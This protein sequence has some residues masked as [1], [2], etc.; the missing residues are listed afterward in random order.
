MRLASVPFDFSL[1]LSI[2]E[3]AKSDLSKQLTE[4]ENELKA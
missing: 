2:R 4:K 1:L 3:M